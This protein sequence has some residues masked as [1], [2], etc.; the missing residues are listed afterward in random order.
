MALP[1]VPVALAVLALAL[2]SACVH[3]VT[4]TDD[5]L[6]GWKGETY[7]HVDFFWWGCIWE[8]AAAL[9]SC[10]GARGT[11]GRA[12]GGRERVWPSRQCR[13]VNTRVF[14]T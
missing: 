4:S 13:S 12:G 10:C 11:A 8:G 2:G 5:I 6:P 3:A 14:C 9:L 7:N 1:R